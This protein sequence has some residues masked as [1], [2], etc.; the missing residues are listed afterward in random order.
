[1]SDFDLAIA[2]HALA[3]DLTIVTADH[4]FSRLRVRRENWLRS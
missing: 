1:M 2:A 3:Y 4:A